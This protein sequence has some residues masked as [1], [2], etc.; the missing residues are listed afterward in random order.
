MEGRRRKYLQLCRGKPGQL[1]R[2]DGIGNTVGFLIECAKLNKQCL[3]PCHILFY[4]IRRMGQRGSGWC[5]RRFGNCC[6]YAGAYLLLHQRL[7]FSWL[8]YAF[9]RIDWA[10]RASFDGEPL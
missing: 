9:R 2:S 3:G 1:D 4:W 6:G 8:E 5:R 10:C 7:L